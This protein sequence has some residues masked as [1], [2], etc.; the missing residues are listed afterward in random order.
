MTKL[1]SNRGFGL[2]LLL[3]I[4]TIGIYGLY[5]IHVFAKETNIVCKED[6]KKT[7]GLLVYI[8][9]SMVTLG[10]YAIV[11]ECMWINR[12]KKYLQRNNKSEGFEVPMYLTLLIFGPVTLG[13]TYLVVLSNT[14]Y[15]QNVVN[16]T[17]NELN[18]L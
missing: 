6:N 5:Q 8:L 12:C 7:S 18:N 13:I 11:W 17:Y 14:I 9:L 1:P 15:L 10:I 3:F 4:I 2:T 16:S